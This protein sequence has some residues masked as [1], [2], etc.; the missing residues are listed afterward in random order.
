MADFYDITTWNEKPWYQTGGTREKCFVENP[1]NGKLYY[2]KESIAKYPSEFWSEIIASKVGKLFGFNLLDYNIGINKNVVGCICEFMINPY[3]ELIHG[4]SL[5]KDANP[6]FKITKAP[7]LLF[8]DIEKSF[9]TYSDNFIYKFLDILIFDSIIGNQDRHSENWAVIRSLDVTNR[10]NNIK[11]LL[12]WV[13]EKYKTTNLRYKKIPF[14]RFLLDYMRESE[15]INIEFAPI[16]DSGSSLGREISE[17]RLEHFLKNDNEIK[18]Y[19]KKGI[20]EIKW[21]IEK[22]NINHFD[23]L[24]MIMPKYKDYILN[25]IKTKFSGYNKED[26][27]KLIIDIDVNLPNEYEKNKLTLQRKE[28]IIKFIIFR[29]EKLNEIISENQG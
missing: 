6:K 4:V 9:K 29:I 21:E 15:L 23:L 20:S 8:K 27:R 12:I 13:Y 17:D 22:K 18:K 25:T 3:D 11:R 24:K 1:E 10:E 16:Y 14:K 26:L 28:L 19:I 7:I 5:L 2:F